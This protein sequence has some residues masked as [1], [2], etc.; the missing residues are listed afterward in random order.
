MPRSV[1]DHPFHHSQRVIKTRTLTSQPWRWKWYV[2]LKYQTVSKL[3]DI[4]IKK[5]VVFTVTTVRTLYTKHVHNFEWNV[6]CLDKCGSLLKSIVSKS[7]AKIQLNWELSRPS[8]L[9]WWP[10]QFMSAENCNMTGGWRPGASRPYRLLVC[11]STA[12]ECVSSHYRIWNSEADVPD[13]ADVPVQDLQK[14][15]M[16]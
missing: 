10:C 2:S 11:L 5:A 15:L 6:I 14:L 9:W 3:H 4:T 13:V 16:E 8:L 7:L 12:T 1:L